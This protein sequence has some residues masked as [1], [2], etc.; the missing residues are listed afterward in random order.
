MVPNINMYFLVKVGVSIYDSMLFVFRILNRFPDFLLISSVCSSH[1][2]RRQV[3]E[4]IY[5]KDA[6]G[7]DEGSYFILKA[8]QVVISKSLVI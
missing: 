5:L 3:L 1:N 4:S 2:E 7:S 8:K 6:Y